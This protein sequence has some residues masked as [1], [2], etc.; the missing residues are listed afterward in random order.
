MCHLDKLLQF[1]DLTED[2][3]LRI[4]TPASDHCL[5]EDESGMN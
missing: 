5:G 3:S 1:M 2:K 4:G